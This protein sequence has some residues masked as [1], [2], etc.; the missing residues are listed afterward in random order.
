MGI[1]ISKD[2]VLCVIVLGFDFVICSVVCVMIFY[3]DFVFMDMII[4]VVFC[5]MYGMFICLNFVE[6]KLIWCFRWLLF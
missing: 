3:F 5:K 1:F 2:V 4:Q 6:I